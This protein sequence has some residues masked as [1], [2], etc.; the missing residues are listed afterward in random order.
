[1]KKTARSDRHKKIAALFLTMLRIGAMTFGGGYAMLALL[2]HEFVEKKKWMDRTEFLDMAAVAESTPGPIAINAA[3]YIG[4]RQ[5][6]LPG[7]AAATVAVCIPSFCIIYLISL[8]FD[9]FLSLRFVF[10]AFQGLRMGVVY[11]IFSVGLR[12][13]GKMEKNVFNVAVVCAVALC[14]LLFSV[15]AVRFSTVYIILICGAAGLLA[16]RLRGLRKKGGA[17][18]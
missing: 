11:L 12:M 16:D 13:L 17:D 9:A 8:F 14:L 10:Y 3:T 7:A 15:F 5:A 6:G 1:M 2:E 4:F 18:V